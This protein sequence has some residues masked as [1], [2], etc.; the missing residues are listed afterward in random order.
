MRNAHGLSTPIKMTLLYA[1]F[2]CLSVIVLGG[3]VFVG[4]R[5][6]LE[7]Q[8]KAHMERN[9]GELLGE[10]RQ[11]GLAELR[12]AI[13]ER[14]VENLPSRLWY[15]LRGPN[16]KVEFDPL[17]GFPESGWHTLEAPEELLV[18]STQ[19][20]DGYT[21]AIT[22]P[23]N[24]IREAERAVSNT[25]TAAVLLILFF[26]MAGGYVFTRQFLAKLDRL[27]KAA[28]TIGNGDLRH[29]I[30]LN[31]SGD[32]FDQLANI[33][34]TMLGRIESLLLEVQQ[35]STNIAH[36]LRT[37]LG[38]IRQ[39]LE[40]LARSPQTEA[41][42]REVI[43]SVISLLDDTLATF[44]ALLRIA[45]LK[46]GARRSG[47]VDVNLTLILENLVTAYSASAE[48][49]GR[50]LILQVDRRLMML[51]DRALL[52][53]LF[54]NL[55]ENSLLHTPVGTEITLLACRV[56]R[57]LEVTVQDNGPGVP[58]K[59]LSQILKPFYKLNR[60]RTDSTGGLGLSLVAAIAKIHDAKLLLSD[61]QPGLR[62]VTVF[63]GRER[64]R[65]KSKDRSTRF[66]R[67]AIFSFESF[68]GYDQ[69]ARPGRPE[70][71]ARGDI[72]GKMNSHIDP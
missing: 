49:S 43:E 53:Q 56:G 41:P 4:I 6:S 16:G 63:R 20:E 15:S 48:E 36:D 19:L 35:V 26:G 23:L 70:R 22:S 55:I 47:F 17:P 7:S 69:E 39:K 57:Y 27:R 2:F 25:F 64:S 66:R 68:T 3:I 72:A 10:Y 62:V 14:L 9:S 29:R 61:A 71:K 44:S 45:E 32:D 18:F 54:A 58:A 12:H 42:T 60:S 33:I 65:E 30:P 5:N 28:D 67:Q 38:R 31:G 50:K 8:L 13:H 11:E 59:E 51:G 37:P 24:E 21:F 52:T 40:T 34:N 1:I 46:S